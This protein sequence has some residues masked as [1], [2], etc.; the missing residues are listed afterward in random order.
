[1]E[2]TSVSYAAEIILL[3]EHTQNRFAKVGFA[4]R[5]KIASQMNII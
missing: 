3:I 2:M 1:M 4:K 5:Q